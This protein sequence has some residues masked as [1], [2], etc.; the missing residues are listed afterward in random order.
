MT[1]NDLAW[2]RVF[3][4]LDLGRVLDQ[5]GQCYLGADQLKEHGRREPRLMAKM[6]TLHERPTVFREHEVNIFPVRNGKYVL[7]KDPQNKTYF[8]FGDALDQTP[9]RSY[10]SAVDLRAFN[11]FP[12]DNQLSES[13]A[14]DFALVAGLLPAFFAERD[15]HLTLRGRLFSDQF[16]FRPPCAHAKPAAGD[17]PAPIDVHKVQIEIDAGYEGPHSLFLLEAKVGKREDFNIRQLYYPFLNWSARSRKKIVPIF[18]TFTNGQY[19][20]TQFAFT[21]T[22]GELGIVRSEAYTINESPFA[23][24]DWQRLLQEIPCEQEEA[25]FPQADDLDKVVD[26]VKLVEA[27]LNEK[28][29]FAEFFEFDERQGDYYANAGKYLGLLRRENHRFDL[30][31]SG[32]A[33]GRLPSRSARILA[34]ARQ[35]ARRPSL[36]HA[37]ELLRQRN[38]LLASLSLGELGGLITNSAGLNPTTAARRA[39]TVRNWMA[40]LLKNSQSC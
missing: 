19:Y 29:Q 16:T 30:T 7:F 5:E 28:T 35:M 36:R 32:M 33:F 23:R 40:W 10:V 34:L 27:G 17:Y 14:I 21:P 31:E 13:Q 4:A 22:F 25:P 12:T 39:L 1:E 38:W 6:D 24:I 18:L 3:A 26:L 9:V 20:L 15:I 2:Q 8:K 37:I 11:S